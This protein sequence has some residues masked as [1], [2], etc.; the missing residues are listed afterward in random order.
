MTHQ[1]R[2]DVALSLAKL[3]IIAAA[4]GTIAVAGWLIVTVAAWI[5]YS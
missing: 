1:Q 5:I 4:I 3:V 2:A